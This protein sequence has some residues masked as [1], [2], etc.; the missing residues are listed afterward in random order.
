MTLEDLFTFGKHK[1]QQLEDIIE[2]DPDYIRWLCEETELHFD[3]EAL[4]LIAKKGIA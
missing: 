3:E 4:E 2:D 1:G